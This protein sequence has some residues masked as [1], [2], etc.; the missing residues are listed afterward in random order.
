M[1]KNKKVK[2]LSKT[3]LA[4]AVILGT[5]GL[6]FTAIAFGG[7]VEKAPYH[8]EKCNIEAQGLCGVT[9]LKGGVEKRP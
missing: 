6:L 8:K 3:K 7:G 4:M 2:K 1:K 9:A 5:M